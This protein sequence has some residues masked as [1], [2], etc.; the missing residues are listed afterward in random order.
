MGCCHYERASLRHAYSALSVHFLRQAAWML[1]NLMGSIDYECTSCAAGDAIVLMR[2]EDR[3]K[4][5]F[6]G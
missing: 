3:V 2:S 6:W 1:V 4:E 5:R